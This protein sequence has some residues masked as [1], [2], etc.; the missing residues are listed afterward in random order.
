[1]TVFE[2]VYQVAANALVQEGCDTGI[3][4]KRFLL[5]LPADVIALQRQSTMP[6]WI[7]DAG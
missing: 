1:V 6:A 7:D 2:L 3:F 4:A 5:T